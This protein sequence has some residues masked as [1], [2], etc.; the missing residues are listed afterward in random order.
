M[1][2]AKCKF[3]RDEWNSDSFTFEWGW[4]VDTLTK[5]IES[6][7]ND[8]SVSEIPANFS[9]QCRPRPRSTL[10]ILLYLNVNLAVFFLAS[11]QSTKLEFYIHEFTHWCNFWILDWRKYNHY[12]FGKYLWILL[13]IPISC[14][15]KVVWILA[16]FFKAWCHYIHVSWS[17]ENQNSCIT[18]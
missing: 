1:N 15:Q 3:L 6:F 12:R 7:H 2:T 10:M 4:Q 8:K 13:W 16:L 9:Q 17:N 5:Y 11:G 14:P 18:F